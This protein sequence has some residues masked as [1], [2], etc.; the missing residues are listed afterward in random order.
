MGN[1]ACIYEV[2]LVG[3]GPNQQMDAPNPAQDRLI[4]TFHAQ[5]MLL[6]AQAQ[7]VFKKFVVCTD[8]LYGVRTCNLGQ[9]G[10]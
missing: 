5:A 10:R 1:L 8:V 3:S 4:R 6:K 2:G 9:S 7:V